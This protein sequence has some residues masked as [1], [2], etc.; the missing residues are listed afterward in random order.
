[1]STKINKGSIN[2]IHFGWIRN[3]I[4]SAVFGVNASAYGMMV[5]APKH[6]EITF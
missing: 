2:I 6:V 5:S 1:M 3:E 4:H